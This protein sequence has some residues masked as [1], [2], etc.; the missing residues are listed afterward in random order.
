M[1]VWCKGQEEVLGVRH[2]ESYEAFNDLLCC[3]RYIL[4]I[5]VKK[6]LQ[7]FPEKLL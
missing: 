2:V 4:P 7:Y 3:L 6:C 1:S 5:A